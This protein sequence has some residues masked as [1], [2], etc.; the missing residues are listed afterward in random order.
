M[1]FI[2]IADWQLGKPFG[3]FDAETRSALTEAQFD[4][5]DV[6]GK[7]AARVGALHV[8][9][10]GDVFDTEGPRPVAANAPMS[11]GHAS[12]MSAC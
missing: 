1:R 8:L 5:I 12:D 7:A 2:H 11:S 6:I 9:V 3:G 10:A 4:A